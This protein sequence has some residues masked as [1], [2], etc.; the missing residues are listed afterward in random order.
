MSAISKLKTI[1]GKAPMVRTIFNVVMQRSVGSRQTYAEDFVE[2]VAARRGI[3]P[4]QARALVQHAQKQFSGGWSGDEYRRFSDQ[5]L[6]TFK[7]LYDDTTDAE[8]IATY[9]FHGPLDFLRMLG[10][11]IPKPKEIEAIVGRLAGKDSV[12]L[13]DYGCGLAHRS[14]AISRQ[15]K[16]RGCKVKLNLVDIR[17]DLHGA[18]L[19]FLC[20][21]YGIPC[22]FIEVS[23]ENLYPDLPSHDYCDNV[24]VLEHVREPV[25]VI[26]K[27]DR[28]LKPGGLFLAYTADQEEEMMHISPDLSAVRARMNEL[29]YTQLTKVQGVP[30]FQK[31]LAS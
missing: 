13:V 7:P 10:Y 24:S 6:E 31:P 5:A 9:K 29:G 2:F 14:L 8:V 28:A 11:A 19:E 16:E 25:L 21:K 15:L 20:K 23:P 1:A 27:T 3:G 26:D 17:K 30:L 4:E 18:F 22:E 12:E